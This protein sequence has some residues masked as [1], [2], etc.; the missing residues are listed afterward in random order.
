LAEWLTAAASAG[1]ARQYWAIPS[2]V[3]DLGGLLAAPSCRS[4][5]Q[6]HTMFGAWPQEASHTNVVCTHAALVCT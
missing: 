1:R 5:D 6:Q 3:H 4:H 2:R